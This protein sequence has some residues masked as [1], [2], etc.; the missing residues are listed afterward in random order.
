MSQLV[1]FLKTTD[2]SDAGGYIVATVAIVL[3]YGA[4]LLS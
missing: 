3:L 4:I 2:R 1:A